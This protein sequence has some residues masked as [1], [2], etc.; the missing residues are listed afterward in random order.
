M[1]SHS[2]KTVSLVQSG[3]LLKIRTWNNTH[4]LF[5]DTFHSTLS[6]LKNIKFSQTKKPWMTGEV[7]ILIRARNIAYRSGDRAQYCM[8]RANLKRGNKVAKKLY[9]QEIKGHFIDG[10]PRRAWQGIQHMTNYKGCNITPVHTDALLAE[11]LNVFFAR[12]EENRLTTP[13][14]TFSSTSL[15]LQQHQMRSELRKVNTRKAFGPDGVPGKV[16]S[17]CADQLSGILTKILNLFFDQSDH[18]CLPK[19]ICYHPCL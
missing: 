4:V 6:L 9:K 17:V 3:V 10:D 15:T 16:L 13:P 1:L 12:F 8:A 2:Y 14:P 19:N 18:P 5:W 11:E 7:R